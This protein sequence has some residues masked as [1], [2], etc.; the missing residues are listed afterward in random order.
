MIEDEKP[1]RWVTGT[2]C[3]GCKRPWRTWLPLFMKDVI[4]LAR[5]GVRRAALSAPTRPQLY[6][7]PATLPFCIP[8]I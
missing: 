8:L 2:M 4:N 1:F 5:T 6:T 3:E 7:A